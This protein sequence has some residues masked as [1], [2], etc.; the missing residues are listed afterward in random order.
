MDMIINLEYLPE[1]YN[2]YEK[3]ETTI[4]V[5]KRDA[6]AFYTRHKMACEKWVYGRP[7][8]V[9]FDEDSGALCIKY[10]FGAWFHYRMTLN[11]LE[12]W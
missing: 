7:E 6:N 3:Y 9:W 11:G 12:W 2:Q 1:P 8:A 5:I 4:A 10:M